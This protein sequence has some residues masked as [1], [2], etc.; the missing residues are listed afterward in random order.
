M[1]K[2]VRR[3][4]SFIAFTAIGAFILMGI[5]GVLTPKWTYSD[6]DYGEGSRYRSF[7]KM[8]DN[9]IDYVVLGVSHAFFA[10]NP[11]QIYA[12]TGYTGY[13]LSGPFQPQSCSY[14][15]LKEAAKTQ[16]IKCV[17]IDVSSIIKDVQ[18][19]EQILKSL[20]LMKPSLNKLEAIK[21]CSQESDTVYSALFPLYRFHERWEELGTEDYEGPDDSSYYIRGSVLRF[22][23]NNG[24]IYNEPRAGEHDVITQTDLSDTEIVRDYKEVSEEELQYFGKIIDFCEENGI[25]CVPVKYP[26]IKWNAEWSNKINEFLK[27]RDMKLIDLTTGEDVS[28]D[29]EKDT[30]DEGG[31]VNYLGAV[32]TSDYMAGYLRKMGIFT[33]HRGEENYEYWDKDLASYK[34]WEYSGVTSRLNPEE[35]M[36]RYFNVLSENNERFLVLYSGLHDPCNVSDNCLEFLLKRSGLDRAIEVE[37]QESM[38]AIVDGGEA[39]LLY[40]EYRKSEYSGDY[41]ASEGSSHEIGMISSSYSNGNESSI[42]FDGEEYSYDDKDGLNLLVVD[43]EDGMVLSKAFVGVDSDGEFL[44][45]QKTLSAEADERLSALQQAMACEGNMTMTSVSGNT[46]LDLQIISSSGGTVLLMNEEGNAALQPEK[47]SDSVGDTV[48]FGELN[49]TAMQKWIT[50]K[51][52]NGNFRIMS[53]YDGLFLTEENGQFVQ[54][55]FI[56]DDSQ[57]FSLRSK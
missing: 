36:Y 14:Y 16:D 7:Y 5:T 50:L 26:T 56:E 24:S 37:P 3:I 15:W 18:N 52:K 2:S 41:I 48:E 20:I 1:K 47:G 43:R 6:K 17:F 57:E 19:N 9:T 33:D 25:E 27:S 32:K 4:L 8:K 12:E 35:N 40:G 44:F 21:A 13:N 53:L 10:V 49:D 38:L 42:K 34:D 31:H 46:S 51:M 30:H 45:R 23:T 11:M 28:I 39:K 22:T 55:E 54:K 29:W